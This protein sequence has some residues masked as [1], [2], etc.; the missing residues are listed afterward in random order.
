MSAAGQQHQFGP[1][2]GAC[3]PRVAAPNNAATA[4][5]L[6]MDRF[7]ELHSARRSHS[8]MRCDIQSVAAV[9]LSVRWLSTIGTHRVK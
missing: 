1:E 4:N 7:K 3:E 9:Y 2:D 8:T 6:V 5:R